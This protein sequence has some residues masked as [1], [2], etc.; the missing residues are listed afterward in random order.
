MAAERGGVTG[1]AGG[2][3]GKRRVSARRC[4]RAW[5]ERRL[6]ATSTSGGSIGAREGGGREAGGTEGDTGG[7]ES[8]PNGGS[9]T[10]EGATTKSTLLCATAG[11]WIRTRAGDAAG[12]RH[13]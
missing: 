4:G 9:K 13:S 7:A 10:A 2:V 12:R 6:E 5:T 3:A 1:A 8:L 11:A